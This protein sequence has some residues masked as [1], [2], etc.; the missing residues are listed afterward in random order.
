MAD[1]GKIQPNIVEYVD[2]GE[3]YN[4]KILIMEM[5]P[6]GTLTDM[7]AAAQQFKIEEAA[8][9][10]VMRQCLSALQYLNKLDLIHHDIKP[11]NI[12][13]ATEDP[14]N[15]KLCDFGAT[16]NAVSVLS[17]EHRRNERLIGTPDYQAPEWSTAFHSFGIDV[18]ALGIV[19][20]NCQGFWPWK[21]E[22]D[23]DG[24]VILPDFGSL[25]CCDLLER[26]L[27][28]DRQERARPQEC[29]DHSWLANPIQ[30]KRRHLSCSADSD[31]PRKRQKKTHSAAREH[32]PPGSIAT[33]ATARTNL[34]HSIFRRALG[35]TFRM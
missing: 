8:T 11:S 24:R 31:H 20:L 2:E 33:T 32:S 34:T 1:T 7:I 10:S 26:M 6:R 27:H 14:I 17:E 4:E 28:V 30:R 29:L 35:W 23:C 5:H 12:L 19:L 16:R 3:L 18:W 25:S 22:L 21:P 9:K 13:I 15:V